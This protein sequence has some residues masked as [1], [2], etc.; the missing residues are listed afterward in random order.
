VEAP[1]WLEPLFDAAGMS[2]IDRWAIEERGVPSLD[3]M[4]AAGDALATEA[5][6]VAGPGP[7][8]I[9]CGKGNNGGDG[10]V[11]ARLLRDRGHEVDV[12]LL[13]P[14]TDLSG[15]AT[16][17]LERLG[18]DGF[19]EIP[20]GGTGAALA[21]SGAVIDA[22]FGTGFDGEPREPARSAIAAANEADAP[23]VACDIAS[24][25]DA[26][27]GEAA[28]CAIDAD[29]TVTFHA[30][31]VGHRIAPGKWRGGRLEVVPIGIP[32]G[33]PEDPVAGTIEAG[34]LG[35]APRR[36]TDSS[37]FSS[38][39]VFVVG[40]SRGMT[41]A[42]CMASMAA[43][44]AGAGY[45][46]AGVPDSLEQ[47]FEV[48]LTE[49]MTVGLEST[50]GGL[51]AA[52]A[53]SV[54]ERSACSGC[55]VLG[56]GLGRADHSARLAREL[57]PRI[58]A[59]L[60]IDADG[61]NALGTGLDQVEGRSGPTILT[62]HAGELGRL[63]DI[64]SAEVGAHRLASAR[65]AAQAAGAV[66]VLKGDDT[67]V[68]DGRSD[69]IAVNAHGSAALAT[70]GTGDVLSGT[71]AALVARGMEPFEAACA[72][73]LAHARAGRRATG[74]VGVESVIATDV[75]AALPWGLG[76]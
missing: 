53:A 42:V 54:I 68:A 26:S 63:L 62:P 46:T 44:R 14:A 50:S 15:D 2:G 51:G 6:A 49:V 28:E 40:G 34:V 10:L 55:V 21:G 22:I 20:E 1:G 7:I 8:R 31:K 16:V 39:E 67:I 66:V 47:I 4:E 71:I 18:D 32:P 45:A 52:A 76:T 27:S 17:N 61:L 69:R 41:G 70:A 72:G 74:E 33:A 65:R 25:V 75:I 30:P 24:G 57:V 37:K 11:A 38:G 9:L 35:L 36:G 29:V 19:T 64:S 56:P 3:L 48:K 5:E 12:L 58:D 60:L 23:V 13:W 43:I 73:V 59:P